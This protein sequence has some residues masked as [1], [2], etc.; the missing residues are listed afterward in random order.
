MP[1]TLLPRSSR[2]GLN[3][4]MP[5]CSGRIATMPPPTPLFAGRP[6][7]TS[8]SPEASYMPQLVMTAVVHRATS[9]RMTRSPLTGLRP[10]GRQRRRHD[11]EVAGV[12]RDRALPE[13]G[14]GRHLGGRPEGSG[15]LGEVGQRAIAVAGGVLGLE[16]RLVEVELTGGE[17]VEARVDRRELLV[18]GVARD[19]R[20]HDD[21]ARVDHGVQRAS[22]CR[23]EADRVERLA[24]RLDADVP[25]D[26]REARLLEREGED[27]RLRHRL[28]RERR[29]AVAHLVHAAA[30]ADERGAEGLGVGVRQLGDVRRERAVGVRP[31]DVEH[32][33]ERRTDRI[34]QVGNGGLVR[35]V[36]GHGASLGRRPRAPRASRPRRS[37]PGRPDER[38]MPR[39]RGTRRREPGEPHRA[40]ERGPRRRDEFRVRRDPR[41]LVLERGREGAARGEHAADARGERRHLGVERGGERRGDLAA[42]PAEDVRRDAITGCRE[43]GDVRGQ[44]REQPRTVVAREQGSGPGRRSAEPRLGCREERRGIRRQP[45][46]RADAPP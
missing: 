27:E 46:V 43:A 1:R 40:V 14:T 39:R 26:L 37:V 38:R 34:A 9:S 7:C 31:R 17:R 36:V 44:P 24:A 22:G 13:V 2:R 45:V 8:Q 12:D 20:A 21:R 25:D 6:T 4:P 3:V 28:D 19:E 32:G 33:V 42:R 41:E 11:R 18:G 35:L 5:N 15:R 30:D 23:L 16:D 10:A 29:L